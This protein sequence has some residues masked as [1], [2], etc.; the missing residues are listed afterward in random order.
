MDVCLST[1]PANPLATCLL[2]ALFDDGRQECYLC[3][4]VG[5]IARNCTEGGDIYRSARVRPVRF[6]A[7]SILN[8]WLN[9]YAFDKC[10]GVGPIARKCAGGGGYR[11]KP[12]FGLLDRDADA[13]KAQQSGELLEP[14]APFT[15]GV[16]RFVS[17]CHSSSSPT[18]SYLQITPCHLSIS[19]PTSGE[20]QE[21]YKCGK[22]GHRTQL[23]RR[24]RWRARVLQVRESRT[25]HAT[26]PKAEVAME[27][28]VFS[29][30]LEPTVEKGS[31]EFLSYIA[32]KRIYWS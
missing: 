21:C 1:L 13:E 2:G 15:A 7:C 22:V 31:L 9:K 32:W 24:W 19:T 20:F 11:D 10:G 3:G 18:P 23:Y 17:A 16:R 6:V 4:K 30:C 5:H 29:R 8:S 14:P 12:V 25:S 26:V 28:R 27:A